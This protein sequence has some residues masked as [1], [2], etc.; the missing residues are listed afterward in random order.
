MLVQNYENNSTKEELKILAAIEDPAA[1]ADSIIHLFQH[2]ETFFLGIELVSQEYIDSRGTD[3][4][5]RYKFDNPKVDSIFEMLDPDYVLEEE[6]EEEKGEMGEIFLNGSYVEQMEIVLTHFKVKYPS[7]YEEVLYEFL[8]SQDSPYDVI[9]YEHDIDDSVITHFKTS[10]I[11]YLARKFYQQQAN[12]EALDL[13]MEEAFLFHGLNFADSSIANLVKLFHDGGYHFINAFFATQSQH[14]KE[15]KN[16][17][18]YIQE[19][20]ELDTMARIDPMCLVDDV[21][22]KATS[23]GELFAILED[24]GVDETLKYLRIMETKKPDQCTKN[25][26]ELLLGVYETICKQE[27]KDIEEESI[28]RYIASESLTLNEYKRDL[29]NREEFLKSL[30]NRYLA[31]ERSLFVQRIDIEEPVKQKLKIVE[32]VDNRKW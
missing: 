32:K 9:L 2:M 3:F 30:L 21:V 24:I 8:L 13:T 4:D 27:K 15:E 31:L 12:R 17:I 1:T 26:S 29:L 22:Y 19:K 5:L 18:R 25:I 10:L 20:N 28:V 23:E 14:E 7:E 16:N 6:L 11:R